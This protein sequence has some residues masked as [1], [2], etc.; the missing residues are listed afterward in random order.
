MSEWTFVALG[1]PVPKGRPRHT[2]NGHTYTPERTVQ[3]EVNMGLFFRQGCVGYGPPRT[4]RFKL[5]CKFYVRRDDADLDNLMKL[6]MDGLQGFAWV[7]DKQVKK[8]GESEIL[9]DRG[10]PRTI[11]TIEEI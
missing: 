10:D 4:G 11:I 1:Q 5:S 7:N 3:A 6:V 2:K 9:V 8:F